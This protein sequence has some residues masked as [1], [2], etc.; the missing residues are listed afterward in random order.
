MSKLP[1]IEQIILLFMIKLNKIY[2]KILRYQISKYLGTKIMNKTQKVRFDINDDKKDGGVCKLQKKPNL[3]E[4]LTESLVEFVLFVGVISL[5][6]LIAFHVLDVSRTSTFAFMGL[7]ASLTATYFKLRVMMDPEYKSSCNCVNNAQ[8]RALNGVLTV[9]DHKKGS[10]LFGIPNSVYGIA[11]YSSLIFLNGFEL[12]F[13]PYLMGL[14]IMAS[15][16][17][18]IY[19][20]YTMVF[21]VKAICALCMTIHSVSFLLLANMIYG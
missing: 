18:S 12:F 13:V 3:A 2:D 16:I 20:W 4:L 11:F 6:G 9:L 21:E 17:G 14:M 8:D 7:L 1:N 19:L 15:A 5:I 10:L